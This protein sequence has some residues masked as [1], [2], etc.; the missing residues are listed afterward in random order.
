MI[1][2]DKEVPCGAARTRSQAADLG[3]RM[4][5]IMR[6][7]RTIIAP[8]LLTIGTVGALVAGPTIAVVTAVTPATTAVA[9]GTVTSNMIVYHT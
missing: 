5:V 3:K 9:A 8:A 4:E 2:R 6:I 7:R 1:K